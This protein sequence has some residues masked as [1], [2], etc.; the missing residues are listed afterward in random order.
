MIDDD[1]VY[2]YLCVE[3][4]RWVVVVVGRMVLLSPDY[5]LLIRVHGRSQ[6]T[7][8]LLCKLFGVGQSS[9]NS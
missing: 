4:E 9:D 8:V 1:K 5:T 2:D 7:F 3:R 6:R